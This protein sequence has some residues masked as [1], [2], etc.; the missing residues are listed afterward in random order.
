MLSIHPST[1]HGTCLTCLRYA[2]VESMLSRSAYMVDNKDPE[3]IW[4][5]KKLTIILHLR[6]LLTD[7]AYGQGVPA[8]VGPSLG[9]VDF[10]ANHNTQLL[11]TSFRDSI[12]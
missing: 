10:L 5:S 8:T 6:A 11:N 2:T 4:R 3:F 9:L 1:V 12:L 7:Y